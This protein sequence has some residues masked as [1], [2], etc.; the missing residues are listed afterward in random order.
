MSAAKYWRLV[1]ILIDKT[2]AGTA[3]WEATSREGTF[4]LS[5]ADYSVWITMVPSEDFGEDVLFQIVNSGGVIID[6]F[7][8]VDAAAELVDKRDAYAK[9]ERLYHAARR[10]GMGVDEALDTLINELG[11]D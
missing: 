7:R 4:A 11:K 10:K 5:L 3:N 2:E 6:S 1:S 8:D 9:M